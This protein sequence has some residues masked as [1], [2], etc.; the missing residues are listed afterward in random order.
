MLDNS[1][2]MYK[3]TVY[4]KQRKKE[5][6]IKSTVQYIKYTYEKEEDLKPEVKKKM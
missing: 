6:K 4:N 3:S 2:L 1:L 5:R